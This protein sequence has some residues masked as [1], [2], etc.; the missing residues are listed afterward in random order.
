MTYIMDEITVVPSE[1]FDCEWYDDTE[2]MFD[3]EE[4]DVLSVRTP[5]GAHLGPA[6]AAAERGIDVLCEKPLEITTERIDGM[7][8]AAAEN[9]GSLGGGFQ[10]RYNP[11][12]QQLY[13]VASTASTTLRT[14]G[15]EPK[16]SMVVAR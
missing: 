16:R 2:S 9:D 4:P 14:A 10:Q 13:E 1:R 8:A 7:R 5:S 3:T 11:V 15:R 12:V 6:L